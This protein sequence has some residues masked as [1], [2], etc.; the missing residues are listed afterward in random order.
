[1]SATKLL[2]YPSLPGLIQPFFSKPFC[3]NQPFFS[4]PFCLNQPFFNQSFFKYGPTRPLFRLFSF[5]QT[6]ITFFITNKCEKCPSRKQHYDSN[7]RPLEHESP[8]ITTKPGLPPIFNQSFALLSL[9]EK[10]LALFA[11]FQP[12]TSL[13]SSKM[14]RN[15]LASQMNR[16]RLSER[17]GW[18]RCAR[19]RLKR[20][21]EDIFWQK[22]V[23]DINSFCTCLLIK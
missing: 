23:T 5:F 11:L 14:C 19:I 4:K 22:L 6:N 2:P 21:T 15:N 1:M 20:S 16:G 18:C 7:L 10:I 17:R 9:L 8:P 13:F 3:L 12:I